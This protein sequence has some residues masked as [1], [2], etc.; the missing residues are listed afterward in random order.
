MSSATF[1]KGFFA[2]A[3]S[4]LGGVLLPIFPP[5]GVAMIAG[6]A[7]LGVSAAKDIDNQNEYFTNEVFS[8]IP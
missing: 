3:S 7:A 1:A 6:G 5:A 2:G 8:I 4:F